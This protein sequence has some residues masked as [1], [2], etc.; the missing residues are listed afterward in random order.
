MKDPFFSRTTCA[1][2]LQIGGIKERL[3]QLQRCMHSLQETGAPWSHGGQDS[4]SLGAILALMAAVLTECDLHCHSQTLGAMAKRLGELHTCISITFRT[5]THAHISVCMCMW[6]HTNNARVVTPPHIVNRTSMMPA[7][8]WS[9]VSALEF[10]YTDND[11]KISVYM[12]TDTYAVCLM[13]RRSLKESPNK[14]PKSPK[15]PH[16]I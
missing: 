2:S 15:P 13:M 4:N 11:E 8:C 7:K 9:L 3:A 14:L 16:A 6:L 12:H 10:N 1:L 5:Q